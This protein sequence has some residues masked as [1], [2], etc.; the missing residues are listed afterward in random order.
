MVN[1]K[2]LAKIAKQIQKNNS[3]HNNDEL[4]SYLQKFYLTEFELMN[5]EDVQNLRIIL[6]I[7]SEF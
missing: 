1:C 6:S 4:I 3:V 7:P 5:G 2:T